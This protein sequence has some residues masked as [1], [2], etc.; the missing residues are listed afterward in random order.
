MLNA[1]LSL[2]QALTTMT[3]A[4]KRTSPVV[5]QVA[6]R[7]AHGQIGQSLSASGRRSQL[8]D[9]FD[10]EL[11]HTAEQ[12]SMKPRSNGWRSGIR[13]VYVSQS[14][15][16]GLYLPAGVVVLVRLLSRYPH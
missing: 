4:D 1:G 12:S 13:G 3:N 5:V 8:F 7:I 6:A 15:R 10:R 9:R 11:M 14:H 16:A 2:E